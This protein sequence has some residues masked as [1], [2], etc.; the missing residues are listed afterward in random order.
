LIVDRP[1]ASNC[2]HGGNVAVR[3]MEDRD[4]MLFKVG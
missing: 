3:A 4:N 2:A 1:M